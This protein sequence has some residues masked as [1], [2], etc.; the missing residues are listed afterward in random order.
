M[1]ELKERANQ[2]TFIVTEYYL[3]CQPPVELETKIKATSAVD[4]IRKIEHWKYAERFT[5]RDCDTFNT[6][7]K[8]QAH[9]QDANGMNG[10]EAV[11]QGET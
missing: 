4:A 3:N 11:I 5:H 8:L 10:C 2:K 6:E 7:G 9:T 1:K